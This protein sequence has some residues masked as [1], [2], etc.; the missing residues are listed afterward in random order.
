MNTFTRN[1]LFAAEVSAMRILIAYTAAV[2]DQAC[3]NIVMAHAEKYD[4][5]LAHINAIKHA[6]N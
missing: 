3:D 2:K 5:A 6:L 4:R 1:D